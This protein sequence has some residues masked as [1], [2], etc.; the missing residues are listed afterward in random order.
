MKRIIILSIIGVINSLYIAA[1]NLESRH[2]NPF[3]IFPRTDNQHIDLSSDW[4]LSCTDSVLTNIDKLPGN[5]LVAVKF[6]TSV[7]MA[8]YHAGKKSVAMRLKWKEANVG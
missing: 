5:S 4:Q 2:E 3:Y 6:P 8:L 7:Q 1:Q